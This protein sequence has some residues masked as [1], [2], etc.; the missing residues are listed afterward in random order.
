MLFLG[1]AGALISAAGPTRDLI[2]HWNGKA[3]SVVSGA[4]AE[5]DTALTGVAATSAG[6]AWTVGCPCAGGPQGVVSARWNGKSWSNVPVP[7]PSAFGDSGEIAAVGGLAWAAGQYCKAR[8]AGD[9][10]VIAPLLMR[11][12]GKKWQVTANP[13]PQKADVGVEGLAV[14]SAS[15]AWAVGSIEEAPNNKTFILHWN[16]KTWS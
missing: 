1:E 13:L 15:N 11:W 9:S 12:T 2:L 10:A 14:T 7:V 3:W 8:C 16:G 6:N 4:H 5:A